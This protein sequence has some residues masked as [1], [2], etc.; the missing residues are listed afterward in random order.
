MIKITVQ[1][2]DR[3]KAINNLSAAI[4][5]CAKA[6]C[7]NVS[8]DIINNSF[9]VKGKN[10]AIKIDTTQEVTKTTIKEVL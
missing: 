6:L 1:T 2:E 5:D 4:R 3:L 7:T 10:P 9:D 8:V